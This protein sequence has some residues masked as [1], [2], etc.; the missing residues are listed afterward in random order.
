ML[1]QQRPCRTGSRSLPLFPD[2]Y[3]VPK[4]LADL[5]HDVIEAALTPVGAVPG[6]VSTFWKL[7]V[8]GAKENPPF[9]PQEQQILDD[10]LTTTGVALDGS[11]LL[12]LD[13]STKLALNL[14]LTAGLLCIEWL[15][16]NQTDRLPITPTGWSAPVNQIK[17]DETIGYTKD[18]KYVGGFYTNVELRAIIS[19]VGLGANPPKSAVYY[20]ALTAVKDPNKPFTEQDPV[21]LDGGLY[22]YTITLLPTYPNVTGLQGCRPLIFWRHAL[23]Q[24]EGHLPVQH[25]RRYS[26]FRL[27]WR[28]RLHHIFVCNATTRGKRGLQELASH[29]EGP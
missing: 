15:S 7:L 18:P 28:Q 26:R 23:Q 4:G 16:F 20:F 13:P 25:Q 27:Q 9:I 21:P 19:R 10:F 1:L 22:N 29:W 3:V 6:N 14:G 24:G 11:N 2:T 8:K 12:G 5:S 17:L